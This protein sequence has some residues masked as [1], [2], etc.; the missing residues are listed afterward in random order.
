MEVVTNYIANRRSF[1]VI[2]VACK[3]QMLCGNNNALFCHAQSS[4]DRIR[5]PLLTLQH[6]NIPLD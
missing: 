4:V 6:Y 5:I 1:L 3:D 2:L